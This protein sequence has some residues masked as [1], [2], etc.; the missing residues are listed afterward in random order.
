MN[1]EKKNQ[2]YI[3]KFYLRNFSYN[4]NGKQIG[5]YNTKSSFFYSTSPLKTQGSKNFLYGYDGKV[6]DWLSTI[7][8]DLAK[9]IK[10]ICE[11]QK[12]P[13]YN[14]DEHIDL[15][16][17]VAITCLRNPISID[18]AIYTSQSLKRI[19][20]KTYPDAKNLEEFEVVDHKSAVEI[21]LSSIPTIIENTIDLKCKI[22]LNKTSI[23][24]IT[25]NF[26]VIKCNNFL[27]SKEWKYS[28]TGYGT[29]GLIIIIPL[30]PKYA[31]IFYD[32]KIY[33]VGD[34]KQHCIE[35][36]DPEEIS[37][38]N[39]LQVINCIDTL[40]FNNE[41]S[42]SYI[43][44]LSHLMKDIPKANHHDYDIY[45][46]SNGQIKISNKK[47]QLVHFKTSEINIELK[48]QGLK[49]NS[50]AAGYKFHPSIVQLREH[51]LSLRDSR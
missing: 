6:E 51:A 26:P 13:D 22:L 40:Y 46:K 5:I 17:F 47:E 18:R 8:G 38:L 4:N 12:A 11:T 35:M 41:I 25:S 24:F 36:I 28:K 34:K 21:S 48:F 31:V 15:L 23:P 19:A 39:K 9:A 29:V 2:H 30:T 32:S 33:K 43:R 42:E 3:P 14:S 7:E 49:Y 45:G 37:G 50:R 10:S 16:A 20:S 1:T 44:K 27:L